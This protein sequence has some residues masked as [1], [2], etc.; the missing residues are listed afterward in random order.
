MQP[1]PEPCHALCLQATNPTPSACWHP[2]VLAE[3]RGWHSEA[4]WL[5]TLLRC[6]ALCISGGG[7]RRVGGVTAGSSSSGFACSSQAADCVHSS[8]PLPPPSTAAFPQPPKSL[9]AAPTWRSHS[10]FT[11]MQE[12]WVERNS[13]ASA[14]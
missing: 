14:A 2:P 3:A 13:S 9:G 11:G 4:V 8:I 5:Q 7:G 10:R 1:P 6:H 12:R